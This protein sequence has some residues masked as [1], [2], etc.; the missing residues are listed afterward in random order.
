MF[1]VICYVESGIKIIEF[2]FLS[3]AVGCCRLLS[4]GVCWHVLSSFG[5][6]FLFK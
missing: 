1:W 3:V 4:S 6:I 5:A 2:T